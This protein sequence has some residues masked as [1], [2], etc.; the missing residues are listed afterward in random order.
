MEA[1]IPPPAARPR[2]GGADRQH[3]RRPL[4]HGL[5]VPGLPQIPRHRIDLQAVPPPLHA[6][7]GGAA[8]AMVSSTWVLVS[9]LHFSYDGF[10]YSVRRKQI[11][12]SSTAAI[13]FVPAG[14]FCQITGSERS[15]FSR[16]DRGLRAQ[17]QTR[18]PGP[19]QRP[20]HGDPG[21]LAGHLGFFPHPRHPGDHPLLAERTGP[22]LHSRPGF[23][24]RWR[25]LVEWAVSSRTGEGA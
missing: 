7:S 14:P 6:D 12:G 20:L 18:P 2:P 9:I 23:R 13:G 15:C 4:H 5:S 22:K 11:S 21:C 19:G 10:L 24:P 17:A 8:R 1:I 3:L 25:P 16:G